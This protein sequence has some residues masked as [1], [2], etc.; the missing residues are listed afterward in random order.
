VA[1]VVAGRGVTTIDPDGELVDVELVRVRVPLIRPLHAAHGVEDIRDV[2]LVRVRLIDG[3]EG[4]GECSALSRPTYTSEHTAG[5]WAVLR[6][7]LVPARLA[8]HTSAVVGHPMAEAALLS[9]E[10]DA[11]LRRG[12]RSLASQLAGLHGA[13]PRATLPVGSVVGRDGS[14][15]D[16]VDLVGRHVDAGAALVKLKVT[17]VHEDIAAVAVVRSLWPDLALAVDFNG[18]A[19]LDA[20]RLLDDLALAYIEQPAPADAL[21]ESAFFAGRTSTPIALDES[22]TGRGT[23]TSAVALGAGSVINVKPGRV[24]GPFVAAQ[25]VVDAG[26]AGVRAFVGGMLETG[27]GRA[28]AAAVAA[29]PGCSLPTD[30]G[31]SSRYLNPDLT[32]PV[33]VD[34]EG[35]LVV[36]DGPGIG[37]RPDP[38]RLAAAS[39]DRLMLAR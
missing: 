20:V 39:V 14:V 27:I 8:G 31:P 24:G 30:L 19:D 2:V 3:T 38:D 16:R 5:A 32:D 13:E 7:E 15:D 33:V 26:E 36:P 1:A 9:A 37:R 21:V 25:M 23:L 29:L 4:W 22:V 12:G 28:T 17:P 6:D 10:A 35:R 34:D 18:T 11:Q